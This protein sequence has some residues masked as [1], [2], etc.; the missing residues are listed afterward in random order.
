[1]RYLKR[2]IITAILL[3]IPILLFY[4]GYLFNHPKDLHPT[5]FIQYDN[6]G[7]AAYAHQYLDDNGIH[8]F[9]SNPFNDSA[10]YPKIY[11][12]PQNIPIAI[13]MKSGIP[14]GFCILI[15]SLLFSFFA[16]LAGIRLYDEVYGDRLK[17][18]SSLWIMTWGGGLLVVTSLITSPFT[19]PQ[20]N[21]HDTMFYLDPALGWW[22]LNF[23]RPLI[24]G[25]ESYYHFL[26]LVGTLLFIKRKWLATC[27]VCLVLSFSHP[28]TGIHF[29]TFILI[30][31]VAE[32]IFW[33]NHNIPWWFIGAITVLAFIH[34][35]YYLV[36]LPSFPDH[37]SVNSQYSANWNYH[38]YHFIPAY[39]LVF[40]LCIGS[41]WLQ[42]FR[43]FIN[44]PLNRLFI[45]L[46]IVSFLLS[47]HEMFMKPMQPIHFARGYEWLSY[48]FLGVPFL[49][50]L[51]ERFN[52]N[53]LALI[54]LFGIFFMDNFLWIIDHI[55]I[56]RRNSTIT[57]L[58]PERAIVL[59]AM[60][61]FSD[62]ETLIIG[63]DYDLP[64]MSTVYTRAY[65]WISHPYTT[66]FYNQKKEAYKHFLET[67]EADKAWKNRKIIFLV[68][69]NDA[70]ENARFIQ[71][72]TSYN[73]L[74]ETEH[75]KLY[76]NVID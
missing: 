28:F 48:F 10:N 35:D 53:K 16:I 17:R 23:G 38:F 22:G 55:I 58:T 60:N 41:I 19:D 11:F 33:K 31:S 56:T 29:L 67:G 40:T 43:I 72:G 76:S 4:T 36:Y 63:G 69:K 70:D 20:A 65:P 18:K 21:I 44:N 73:L 1:L 27:V 42:S 68:N 49:H 71:S 30:L 24:F 7:Y 64:Y 14:P 26:F 32:K 15:F 50:Y 47:N 6:V 9:Y 13:L 34:I 75:Y 51:I 66:S 39:I 61:Q 12:Q 46:A 59:K 25:L 3:C 2:N 52:R 57:Y 37:A 5:G 62:Q 45:V 74:F 54:F 8:L